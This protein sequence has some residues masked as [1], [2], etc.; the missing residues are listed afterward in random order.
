MNLY[1]LL[2]GLTIAEVTETS[3]MCIRF[4]DGSELHVPVPDG[5]APYL[6]PSETLKAKHGPAQFRPIVSPM[7][8]I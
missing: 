6:V 5:H 7:E 1:D 2:K 3:E 8:K 4:T